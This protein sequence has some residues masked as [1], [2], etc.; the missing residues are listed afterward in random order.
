M[1]KIICI[2]L[3]ISIGAG[4]ARD[5][6][7]FTGDFELAVITT[8]SSVERSTVN[9][10]SDGLKLLGS[11]S[12]EY[13]E[14]GTH[15]TQPQ[16]TDDNFVYII[17]KGL[18]KYHNTKKIIGLNLGE[19]K[20]DIVVNIDKSNI[21]SQAISDQ[22]VF[23]ASNL[24]GVS[25]LSRIDKETER[26][27]DKE[28]KGEYLYLVIA[29]DNHI[30]AF[31]QDLANS[32]VRIEVLNYNLELKKVI[33][34]KLI[35]QNHSK[36]VIHNKMLYLSQPFDID[37]K[38][39]RDLLVIDLEL[40]EFNRI[41]TL[42]SNYPSDIYVYKDNL[43]ITHTNDVM[44]MGKTISVY[45]L[46][47]EKDAVY[48]LETKIMTS[49]LCENYLYIADMEGNLSKF[50]IENDFELVAKAEIDVDNKYISNIIA[51]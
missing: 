5:I 26:L 30:Y 31:I 35:G 49:A 34:N 9:Y 44:P 3:F 43:L 2:L 33:T 32:S 51:K 50:D 18:S 6:N 1:K 25:Y 23:V 8:S 42:S 46:S 45:N 36:Y 39:V 13:A 41:I 12:Y 27:L 38:A 4:C 11:N 15:F 16:Y 20:K 29:Y 24:N 19:T 21:Q 48:M 7:S 28:Y 40:Q 14:F 47:E 37:D 22:Y 17:P 10:F